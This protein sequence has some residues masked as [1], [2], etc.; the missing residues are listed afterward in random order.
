[1][2]RTKRDWF[3]EGLNILTTLGPTYLT[4]DQLTTRLEVTKGS[5]YHHFKTIQDFKAALLAFSEIEGT[6]E[7]IKLAEEADTAWGKLEKLL[8][9]TAST[10]GD[11]EISLRA[12]ARQDE[13]ARAYQE[14]VDSRRIAYLQTLCLA[15]L[16]D[17]QRAL[18][19]AQMLYIA[20]VGSQEIIPPLE[21]KD[22][23][24]LYLEIARSYGLQIERETN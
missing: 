4:I 14:K 2:R 17:D 12:W 16:Y 8:G 15:L 9:L 7:F 19:M 20:Y 18:T 24:R 13:T 10:P 21:G 1:M 23:A 3:F 11:F 22:R 6:S 5:F